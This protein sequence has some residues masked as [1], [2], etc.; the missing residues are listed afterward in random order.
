MTRTTTVPAPRLC[1]QHDTRGSYGCKSLTNDL[2]GEFTIRALAVLGGVKRLST[3][4]KWVSKLSASVLGFTIT[5][6]V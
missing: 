2:D 6:Y 4:L 1:S 5:T 3:F